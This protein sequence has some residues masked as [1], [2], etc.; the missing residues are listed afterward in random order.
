LKEKKTIENKPYD[1]VPSSYALLVVNIL[2]NL[3]NVNNYAFVLH[4]IRTVNEGIGNVKR[5]T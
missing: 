5:Y 1:L 4:F 2:L 3:K